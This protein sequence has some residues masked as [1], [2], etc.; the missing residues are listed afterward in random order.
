MSDGPALVAPD[1]AGSDTRLANSGANSRPQPCSRPLTDLAER[2][3]GVFSARGTSEPYLDGIR[4]LAVIAIV[5]LHSWATYGEP[6]WS[7]FGQDLTFI[8]AHLRLGVD[9]FFLLS[10]F[11]LARPWFRS[12]CDGTARPRLAAFWLRRLYRIV[13]AYYLS[14]IAVLFLFVPS[15]RIT[16]GAIEGEIGLWNLGAHALFLQNYVPLSSGFLNGSNDAWWSLTVEMTWYLVLP[17]FAV[18]FTGRRWRV[19]LPAALGITF[20]WTALSMYSLGGLVGVMTRSVS[21]ETA[22]LVGLPRPWSPTM[23][24]LLLMA[25]PS[26]AF[27]FALGVGLARMVVVASRARNNSAPWWSRPRCATAIFGLGAVFCVVVTSRSWALDG[28]LGQD[29]S[30]AS[31]SLALAAMLYGVTFGLPLLRR[32]LEWLPLRYIGWVSYGIYLFHIPVL[33]M[34][35]MHS[36][37]STWNSSVG[38]PVLLICG[39][40]ISTV[41]ATAS[42]LLVERP[43]LQSRKRPSGSPPR[44]TKFHLPPRAFVAVILAISAVGTYLWVT[45]PGDRSPWSAAEAAHHRDGIDVIPL[46]RPIPGAGVSPASGAAT[47]T[48]ASEAGVIPEVEANILAKCMAIDTLGSIFMVANGQWDL[49][50]TAFRCRDRAAAIAALTELARLESAAGLR[51]QEQQSAT[52]IR[53]F[54]SDSNPSNPSHP[55][56]LH[57]RYLHDST[58]IGLIL[59]AKSDE[60]ADMGATKALD[61]SNYS[62]N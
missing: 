13:P 26:Y 25:F 54:H 38:V 19:A 9:L 40:A 59:Q 51:L 60:S 49:H 37:I 58:V 48:E 6:S 1:G 57:L 50:A 55:V 14:L 22:T 39:L 46:L 20:A 2:R 34:I 21:G 62:A 15:G 11:L 33:S 43:F 3:M 52:P 12:E 29:V 24:D 35:T 27:T 28:Q 47:L 61:V 31:C 23:R 7:L 18:A 16:Q 45:G 53:R 32:P 30:L 42:W 4:A 36:D 10:G 17:L 5:I 44:L 56:Q 41:V 8:P